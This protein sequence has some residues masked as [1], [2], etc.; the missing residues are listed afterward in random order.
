MIPSLLEKLGE[1]GMATLRQA[2]QLM[3][4]ANDMMN[5]EE[6]ATSDRDIEK[7]RS[8]FGKHE[9]GAGEYDWHAGSDAQIA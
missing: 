4:S 8:S 9:T 2:R 7:S 3:A 6:P 1:N 5:E